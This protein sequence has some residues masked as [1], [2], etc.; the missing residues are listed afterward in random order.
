MRIPNADDVRAAAARIAGV[1]V[2][3]PLL[4]CAV[5]GQLAGGRIFIKPEMLQRTGSFKFRGAWNRLSQL[6]GSERRAGVVAWSSGNHA[7]GVAAAAQMLGVPALIVM[8]SDAPRLK[9]ERTRG[10]GAEIVLYDR[11]KEMRE[12]IGARIAAE[13]GAVIVRPYDDPDIVAGQ[14]TVGLEIVEDAAQFG[15]GLDAVLVP[16]GGGG[17]AAGTVLALGAAMP[18]AK[19][20]CVEPQ[21]FDDHARS[22]ATGHRLGNE[23]GATSFCDALLAPMPGELTFAINAPRLAG[24]LAVSDAE[25]T[26][27]MRFAF[28]ELKLVVEPGG[29]VALAAVL[30]GRFDTKG[31][32]VALVLSGG[33]ADPAAFAQALGG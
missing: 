6:S 19:V 5:L 32:A 16:A 12:E 13:R 3:T 25:V 26:A 15:I 9:I 11:L 22:L 4:E 28:E 24:G 23:A 1:A 29:A 27:A 8:P 31:K 17:L 2:R 21:G 18:D 33:N 7:Q 30:A 10:F 14:G 20:W